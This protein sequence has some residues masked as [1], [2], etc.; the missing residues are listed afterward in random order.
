MGTWSLE[1]RRGRANCK[2]GRL[3]NGMGPDIDL[4]KYSTG[5]LVGF[6]FGL[7]CM[8]FDA[9]DHVLVLIVRGVPISLYALSRQAGRPFHI[10]F[11]LALWIGVGLGF[12]LFAGRLIVLVIKH[13]RT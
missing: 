3:G 2:N 6:S 10:P 11:L 13:R 1:R 5:L 8:V 7:V 12:A 4:P 9:I